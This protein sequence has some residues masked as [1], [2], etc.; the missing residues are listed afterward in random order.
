MTADIPD[1]ARELLDQF[2]LPVIGPEAGSRSQT[3]TGGEL[4]GERLAITIS[5]FVMLN[6]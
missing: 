5:L 2:V 4:E 3:T 1:A 6:P